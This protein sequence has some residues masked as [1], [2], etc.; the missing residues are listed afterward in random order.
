MV[1]LLQLIPFE[2]FKSLAPTEYTW[3]TFFKV[4]FSKWDWKQLI[5]SQDFKFEEGVTP[6]SNKN[7]IFL[8]IIIYLTTVY[9]IKFFMSSPKL[10]G[11]NL[12]GFS[13]LHNL[14][15]CVWSLIMVLGVTY[16][17]F[18]LAFNSEY[19]VDG[20]FCS[21]KSNPISGRIFYWHYLYF[22]SKFYEFIDTIIIVL[23]KKPLI[24]LHIWHH[25]IVVLIVWT[26]L[27]GGVSYGSIGLF[28]NTLVHVFMYYYY[29][30]TAWNPSVRIWWKSYLTSGQLF[31]FTM[32][33][34]L[35]I[36][37]LLKDIVINEN[38][39]ISHNCVG[40]GAFMFTMFNNLFF[41]ILFMN[42]Y[43]KTY[44]QRPKSKP[45]EE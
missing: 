4:D 2:Y 33:F 29:F 22:V 23:K 38:G 1:D 11:W 10:K 39:V 12:R 21:P 26:W 7:F 36:P 20:F 41:L 30:R 19:G 18:Q 14:I 25:S 32:S 9:S 6:F 8:T 15:L 44:I 17:A 31:Q 45:K 3:E 28:A 13:A 35:S 27:P 5:P 16:D 24:F 40:W 37:F 42:F 43:I 34:V